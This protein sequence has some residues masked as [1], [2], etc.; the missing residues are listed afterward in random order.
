MPLRAPTGSRRSCARICRE[1]CLYS[2]VEGC[3]AIL[4]VK[5]STIA[6]QREVISVLTKLGMHAKSDTSHT[7]FMGTKFNNDKVCKG[8]RLRHRQRSGRRIFLEKSMVTL[9]T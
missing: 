4:E 1:A 3:Y 6:A 7:L 9:K 8:D 2:R 5:P